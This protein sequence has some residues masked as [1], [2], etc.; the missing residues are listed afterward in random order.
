MTWKIIE[1]VGVETAFCVPGCWSKPQGVR[2]DREIKQGVAQ[3]PLTRGKLEPVSGFTIRSD[4]I[5]PA[6]KGRHFLI[7]TNYSVL[8]SHDWQ[9]NAQSSPFNIMMLSQE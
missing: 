8:E 3:C 9:H 2:L 4:S 1:F 6:N 7:M 5:T